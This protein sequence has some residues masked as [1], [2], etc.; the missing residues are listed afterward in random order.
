MKS[1]L[2]W[3]LIGL[4]LLLPLN[5]RAAA[6]LVL[7]SDSTGSYTLMFDALKEYYGGTLESA[8]L[9]ANPP[10]GDRLVVSLGAR[11]CEH[12]MNSA[13]P[14]T[15]VLCTFLPAQTFEGLSTTTPGKTLLSQKRLSALYLDQPLSRQMQLAKLLLPTMK[16][17]GTV[18]GPD[19]EAQAA[20]FKASAQAL[21]LE[22]VVG[23]L[24]SDDNPVKVLTPII[25]RSDLFLPLPD[26]SVFNRAA[27]KWILYISLRNKV[28]L[29]G[30]SSKYADAGAVVALHTT[31]DQIAQE[32]A[33]WIT[34]YRDSEALK[35]PAY[36]REFSI[37]VN[38]TAA[39]NLDLLLPSTEKLIMQLEQTEAR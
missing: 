5:A 2:S 26:R 31:V 21:G 8:A 34:D 23:H 9:P 33:Q 7:L 4:A 27:A 25:E 14:D 22:P 38:H 1:L 30:F 6:P 11:A 3:I 37:S 29:I 15:R 35:A 18:L 12:A 32:C 13:D 20:Q 17:I 39:Q 28:P 36:P 19:S 16:S 24:G 10:L